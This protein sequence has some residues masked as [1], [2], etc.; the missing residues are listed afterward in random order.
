MEYLGAKYDDYKLWAEDVWDCWVKHKFK[1]IK[2]K[3]LNHCKKV[4]TD[5]SSATPPTKTT[6]SDDEHMDGHC[7][8]S[9]K[10]H[11]NSYDAP[12]AMNNGITITNNPPTGC[13]INSPTPLFGRP[14]ATLDTIIPP[15]SPMY[16]DPPI[17]PRLAPQIRRSE[18]V[19][20]QSPK[21]RKCI[22]KHKLFEETLMK[23]I[24]Q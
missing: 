20:S 10:E 15:S 9:T 6:P 1:S 24:S 7:A 13:I 16:V 11:N 19:S 4:K 5:D 17:P 3:N 2:R 14:I 18:S 21:Q 12:R 8:E 23:T 22:V